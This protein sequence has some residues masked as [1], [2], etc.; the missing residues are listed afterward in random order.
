MVDRGD[1][2]EGVALL[3]LL[4]WRPFAGRSAAGGGHMIAAAKAGQGQQVFCKNRRKTA[5]GTAG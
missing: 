3:D 1:Q 2:S 4:P 5:A